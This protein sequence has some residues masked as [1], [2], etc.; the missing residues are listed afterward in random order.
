MLVHIRRCHSHIAHLFH[1]LI[2]QFNYYSAR[3][4]LCPNTYFFNACLDMSETGVLAGTFRHP[5][6]KDSV[7]SSIAL[8]V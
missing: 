4:P 3:L 7:D 6:L 1:S 2:G 8:V 5:S